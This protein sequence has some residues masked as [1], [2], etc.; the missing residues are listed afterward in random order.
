MQASIGVAVPFELKLNF[1]FLLFAGV[2][3]PVAS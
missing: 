3:V 1:Q 2:R